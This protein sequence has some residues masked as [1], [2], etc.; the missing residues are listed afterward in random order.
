[1]SSI[2]TLACRPDIDVHPLPTNSV[3]RST[4]LIVRGSA[5]TAAPVSAVQSIY[6]DTFGHMRTSRRLPADSVGDR[7]REKTFRKRHERT[8]RVIEEPEDVVAPANPRSNQLDQPTEYE[9]IVSSWSTRN[10]GLP[11]LPSS[12]DFASLDFLFAPPLASDSITVAESLEYL[13]YFTSANGMAT[14]LDRETLKQRQELLKGADH[15]RAKEYGKKRIV[16][17]FSLHSL[18]FHLQN[19]LVF[20]STLVPV[21]TGLKNW[22]RI[23]NARQPEDKDVPDEPQTI[24]KKIGFARYAPEL[25]HLARIIVARII[26]SASDE[27]SPLP[28]EQGLSRFNH[29]VILT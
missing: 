22:H 8:C 16:Q 23:W 12:V 15:T 20:E 28:A 18:I 1:M 26:A 11:D 29:T 4:C 7:S 9:S 6:G 27:Q 10:R 2:L 3:L 17:T 19:S 14:F 25:W 5:H 21:K 13:T 24:W